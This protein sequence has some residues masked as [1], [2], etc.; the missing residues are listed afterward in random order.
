MSSLMK[1][2]FKVKALDG[3]IDLESLHG[4]GDLLYFSYDSSPCLWRLSAG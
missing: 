1:W 3:M 4:H 2:Q